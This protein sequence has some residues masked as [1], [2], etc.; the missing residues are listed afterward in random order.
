M[1]IKRQ[2]MEDQQKLQEK[3]I[4]E[5]EDR[6]KEAQR[7]YQ[8]C[9]AKE[10]AAWQE[11]YTAAKTEAQ[12]GAFHALV[13]GFATGV[14]QFGMG[15]LKGLFSTAPS[16]SLSAATQKATKTEAQSQVPAG[17]LV[18]AAEIK[19]DQIRE[20]RCAA[21]ET[22]NEQR[23]LRH[24]ALQKFT[25][26]AATLVECKSQR[27]LAD[28]AVP[29]LH[30]AMRGLKQLSTVMMQA[31]IFWQ[32]M[33]QHCKSLAESEMK[34]QVK[35]ALTLPEEKRMKVWTSKPFKIK[36]VRFYAGWVA[37]HM[38]CTRYVEQI[39]LTGKDLYE[40]IKENPTYEEAGKL[41]PKLAKKIM[42]D[43]EA[44]QQDIVAQTTAAT[45]EIKALTAP[46]PSDAK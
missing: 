8:E 22:A 6:E 18:K 13:N 29:A 4:K 32:Q 27:N 40:I 1:D 17:G 41:L 33:Q 26:F 42:A 35:T 45:N 19:A 36:A 15:G 37:L 3:L 21:L 23:E 16:T 24:S 31:A 2:K 20:K 44:A 38:V 14:S 34:K 43:V 39:K 10:E 25:E 28:A 9:E 30:E 11:I 7:I 5:A 46:P 12:L